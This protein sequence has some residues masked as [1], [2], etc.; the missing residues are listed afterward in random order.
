M[1]LKETQNK[2]LELN[3]SEYIAKKKAG[4][5]M[6]SYLSWSHA[7]REVLKIS[8]DAKYNMIKDENNIP[9]F[10]DEDIGYMV[11][12]TV[13]IDNETKEMW[14]P[15]LNGANKA[16]KKKP[17]TY[18]VKGWNGAADVEKTVE[19]MTMFDVNTSMMRCLVKNLAMFGLGLYIYAGEDL[20]E[21]IIREATDKD[22]Q[23]MKQRMNTSKYAHT[24]KKYL[25]QF[26]T[27][28]IITDDD[29]RILELDYK[30]N[31]ESK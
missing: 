21:D 4:K 22:V 2:L 28:Y 13:T 18:M 30:H 19:G 20:P 16:M 24:F 14:L 23:E 25:K 11:Y 5:T 9:Y 1:M 10:G 26:K 17:Y 29:I 27:E 8:P 6:L 15:V 7:W 3:C 31:K 12:T